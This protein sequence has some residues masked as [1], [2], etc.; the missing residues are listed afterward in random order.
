MIRSASPVSLNPAQ[1][2]T[3]RNRLVAE[4]QRLRGDAAI[5]TA[6]AEPGPR[7]A[8]PS[9]EASDSLVQHEALAGSQHAQRHLAEVEA[10][11]VRMDAGTYGVSEVSGEP[12]GYGRLS[13]VPWA[14]FT[15]AEQ[16]DLERAQRR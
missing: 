10:A 2:S 8:D 13:A 6:V 5:P 1:L 7:E 12:I 11:L 16:E 15:V 3:L 14:R 9:D 4:R